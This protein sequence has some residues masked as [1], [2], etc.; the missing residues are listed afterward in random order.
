MEEALALPELAGEPCPALRRDIAADVVIVGGGYTG[1]WTAYF[2]KE[3]DPGVDVV[4]LEQDVCGGGP[5]GR[6]G[7]FV[8]GF[9]DELDLLVRLYG[10]ERGMAV[11]RAASEQVTAIGTWCREHRVDAWYAMSGNL[12]V[13]T[14]AAQDAGLEATIRDAADLGIAD[15]YRPQTPAEVRARCA[16]PVFRAGVFVSDAAIVQ[17]ARLAR[18]LRRVVLERG[19]RIFEGAPVRRFAAGP[20]AVAETP[21]GSVRAERAVLGVNA[22]GMHW[23]ALRRHVLVRGTFIVVT[24]PA[25]ERLAE[26][27][28]TDGV[29]IYDFRSALHYLRTTPDGRIAFGGAGMQ[30]ASRRRIGP[31]FAYDEPSVRRLVDD[32]HRWFP[33]F[34]DV[35]LEAAWGGP[36]DVSGRHLPFIGTLPGGVAHYALGFTGNGVGPCRLAG[37]I[38]AGLATGAEDELTSLPIVGDRPMAF[39]A[40]P[41]LIPGER[42]V[43][44]AILRKDDQEDEGRRP[45]PLTD[46][47]AHVP[48]RLGYNLGP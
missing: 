45:D 47:L 34:R 1:M 7:G 42:I 2:L 30:V 48:R 10:P 35:P 24:D 16:S 12:G 33:P 4:L 23:R 32:L 37:A 14:S 9:W 38:L 15:L 18:G 26:L 44:T 3:R 36:I 39:P 40:D 41:L 19:V 8:N 21:G 28:W 13:S 17:P 20:A 25:P 31:R 29:G 5:S 43:T 46:L 11:A 6:N 27:G 22:W